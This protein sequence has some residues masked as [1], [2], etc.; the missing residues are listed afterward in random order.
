MASKLSIGSIPTRSKVRPPTRWLVLA[1]GVALV[2]VWTLRPGLAGPSRVRHIVITN[3]TDYALAIEVAGIGHDGWVGLGSAAA[4]HV[5]SID[6]VVDQGPT[7]A[8]RVQSQGQDAG[9]FT[10]SRSAL[11]RSNWNVSIPLRI[12]AHL[13]SAGVPP[14]PYA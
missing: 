3:D 4:R 10:L 12:G 1:A 7:W 9:E 8:F 6:E 11:I 2:V 14:S 5:T 13:R